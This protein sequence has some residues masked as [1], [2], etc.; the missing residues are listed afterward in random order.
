MILSKNCFEPTPTKV[1]TTLLITPYFFLLLVIP[2]I[3]MLDTSSLYLSYWYVWNDGTLLLLFS[4]I[5]SILSYFVA[6]FLSLLPQK[7]L[8]RMKFFKPT[9]WKIA[10]T[11]VV[12]ALFFPTQLIINLLFPNPCISNLNLEGCTTTV[13]ATRGI[14][15]KAMDVVKPN[16]F[17]FV[18]SYL[19]SCIIVAIFGK[20][21]K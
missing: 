17:L 5:A 16:T 2:I 6:C 14:V 13:F 18:L 19:I 21:R 8:Y 4:V 3:A 20:L 11:I 12:I 7:F 15:I 9:L 10:L 1:Y